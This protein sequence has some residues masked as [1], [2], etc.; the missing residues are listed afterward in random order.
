MLASCGAG[1]GDDVNPQ[2]PVSLGGA[3]SDGARS[4]GIVAGRRAQAQ[5]RSGVEG[6]VGCRVGGRRAP[7]AVL[8]A[9]ESNNRLLDRVTW[10]E[11]GFS[12]LKSTSLG[13]YLF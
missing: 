12:I 10:Q 7:G 13:T 6:P 11:E 5:A 9:E 1:L 4:G 2:V 8:G 3:W